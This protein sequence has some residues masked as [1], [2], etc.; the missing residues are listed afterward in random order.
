M[1]FGVLGPLAVWTENGTP[2][3]I[4]E[5]KVRA[6]LADL[7]AAEGRPIPAERLIEDLW[8]EQL[9]RNPTATLQTRVSQLRRALDTAE[10]GARDL[11]VF[12]PPGYRLA[13]PS[14]A[15]DSGR[16]RALVAQAHTTTEPRAR[17]TLLSEALDL[18]RG[19]AYTDFTDYDFARSAATPLD[20]EQVTA[21]GEHA[22]ARLDLGEHHTLAGELGD[23]VARH[24]LCERLRTVQLHALY[25]SGRQGEALAA[26]LEHRARLADE[27]GVDPSPEVTALYEAILKQDPALRP[28]GTRTPTNLPAAV[29]TL[30]GRTDAIARVRALMTTTRLLT[31][32]GPGGVGKSALAVE[33]ARG[34]GCSATGGD[35]PTSATHITP[36]GGAAFDHGRTGTTIALP[37]EGDLPRLGVRTATGDGMW[38]IELSEL[39][40]SATSVETLVALIAR[41]L[42]IPDTRDAPHHPSDLEPADDAL[43][44]L[45]SALAPRQLLLLLDNCDHVIEPVATVAEAILRAAPGVHILA[46]SREPLA[47]PGER[48]W[49][50]EPLPT[51]TTSGDNPA[52]FTAVHLFVERAS[53]TAP[54][55]RLTPDNAA[56]VA[57]ITRHLDGIPL[58]IEL[59]ATQVRTL[60]VTELAA[61]LN[62]RFAVLTGRRGGPARHRSLRASIDWSWRL[63]TQPEQIVLSHLATHADGFTLATAVHTVAADGID[64]LPVLTRLIDR[65]LVTMTDGPGGTHYALLESIRAYALEHLGETTELA[66]R[67]RHPQSVPA[68]PAHL[69]PAATASRVRPVPHRSSRAGS[70]SAPTPGSKVPQ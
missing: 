62:N 25:Q 63:L 40:T 53:A 10:P 29:T 39:D 20:E 5:V 44:R 66:H 34:T 48:L 59:A 69:E 61:R 3:P 47:I 50:V 46:T 14:D 26:Y 58:A 56:A 64:A 30:I 68:E 21:L 8:G 70:L 19:P 51:P 65:S 6:L 12:Q 52:S 38:L 23:L 13:I 45:T 32:T 2:V 18:W 60:G 4:P 43:R 67:R 36:Q 55:F 15:V 1:R 27:L 42:G 33:A 17:A 9:P 22:R 11:V 37:S 35:I 54:S 16:F 31:L 24:P 7:L 28:T 57:D 41:T 49:T